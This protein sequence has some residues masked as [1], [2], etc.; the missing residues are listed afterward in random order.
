MND[1]KVPKH[2]FSPAFSSIS[3]AVLVITA[4]FSMIESIESTNRAFLEVFELRSMIYTA[5][6]LARVDF[7]HLQTQ[8]TDYLFCLI[9]CLRDCVALG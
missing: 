3:I 5:I 1:R 2:I 4:V 6:I 9:N 8:W 7:L